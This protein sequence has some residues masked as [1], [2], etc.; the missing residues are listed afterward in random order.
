[1]VFTLPYIPN[2]II[3]YFTVDVILLLNILPSNERLRRNYKKADIESIKQVLI[4]TNWY[5]LFLNKDVHQQAQIS[6]DTLT[7]YLM[8]FSDFT[9]NKVVTF[10]DRDSPWMTE[11]TKLKIQ[12]H[13]SIFKSFHQK[14]QRVWIMKFCRSRKCC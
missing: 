13:N 1:M 4:L 12:Q 3:I 2:V 14:I 7:P 10:D 8:F 5:H 6:T 9:P 11:F